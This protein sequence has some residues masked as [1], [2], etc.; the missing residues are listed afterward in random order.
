[1]WDTLYI[2]HCFLTEIALGNHFFWLFPFWSSWSSFSCV[3]R[4]IICLIVKN[5]GGCR[6]KRTTPLIPVI[7][8][9]TFQAGYLREYLWNFN[10]WTSFSLVYFC[11]RIL[12]YRRLDPI[13]ERLPLA[14][15]RVVHSK[16]AAKELKGR[17]Y[18]AHTVEVWIYLPKSRVINSS[19]LRTCL[20]DPWSL[21]RMGVSEPRDWERRGWWLKIPEGWLESWGLHS[22]AGDRQI[23][24]QLVAS[25]C[26]KISI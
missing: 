12:A 4:P 21:T 17:E 14:V 19:I 23:R 10:R 1:M 2:P 5:D 20:W 26:R 7:Y 6:N 24:F 3:E 13:P 15:D 16:G 11:I 22:C 18:L 8:P 9:E 25:F